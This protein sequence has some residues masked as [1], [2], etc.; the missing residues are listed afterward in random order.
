MK[1]ILHFFIT[2]LFFQLTQAQPPRNTPFNDTLKLV[3][4]KENIINAATVIK[5]ENMGAVVNTD[6]NELRP[7]ISADGN[8]LFFIRENDPHNTNYNSVRNSQDIWFSMRDE[9]G[10]WSKAVHLGYPLNTAL[11]NSVFWI[12]PDN[13]RI[14]IRGAFVNG[15]YAGT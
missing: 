11:Y 15:D 6:R 2:V 13:N 7:T 3:P 1:K 10:T 5:V 4:Q 12:S 14:L 8:L 9:N